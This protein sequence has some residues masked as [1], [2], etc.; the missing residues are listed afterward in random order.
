MSRDFFDAIKSNEYLLVDSLLKEDPFLVLDFDHIGMTGLHW[1]CKKGHERVAEILMDYHTDIE[2]LDLLRRT[3][4]DLAKMHKNEQLVD[5]LYK[6]LR[7]TKFNRK[8]QA[9]LE[10][11]KSNQSMKKITNLILPVI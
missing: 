1:A 8:R 9:V 6:T 11:L 7:V 4:I 10:S 5:S 3:P 2:K